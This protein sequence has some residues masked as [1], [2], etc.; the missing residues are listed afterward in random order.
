MAATRAAVVTGGASGLGAAVA[1]RLAGE[2]DA[3]VIAD[4]DA[5]RGAALAAELGPE[6]LFAE[7]DVTDPAA[8]EAACAAAA[9]RAPLRLLCTCAGIAPVERLLGSR[10]VHRAEVFR[11]TVMIN[12][13]GTFNALRAAVPLMRE[14]EPEEG[15]DRGVCVLTASIAAFE[16]QVGQIA[17]AASKGGVASMTLAAARDL[18]AEAIRVC[19]IAP[20]VFETPMVSGLPPKAQEAL[21][22]N[23]PHPPRLGRPEEFAELVATIA[24]TPMLNGEVVRLDGA[25]R[26]A[27][28]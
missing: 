13:V 18:A 11:D 7:V 25:L 3:V 5:E 6:A 20:G 26:M 9:E 19:T 2:G 23:V 27:P 16:G 12:L 21:A 15:G 22:A 17:Y 28:R 10:G 1:R 14:N 8:L 4:R 24:A